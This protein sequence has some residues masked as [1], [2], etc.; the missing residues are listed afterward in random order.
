MVDPNRDY[1]ETNSTD[2]WHCSLVSYQV[3]DP[4]DCQP[5]YVFKCQVFL[6]LLVEESRNLNFKCPSVSSHQVE[7]VGR[8]GVVCALNR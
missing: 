6:F 3:R 2:C 7:K 1:Y 4:P 5:S 8:R